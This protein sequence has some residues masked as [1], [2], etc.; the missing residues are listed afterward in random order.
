MKREIITNV[1]WDGILDN[2]RLKELLKN[3]QIYTFFKNNLDKHITNSL[4]YKL[5]V[6]KSKKQ[7]I[8]M[9]DVA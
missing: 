3:K 8:L 9:V 7:G 5:S 4:K 1:V 2:I 6:L